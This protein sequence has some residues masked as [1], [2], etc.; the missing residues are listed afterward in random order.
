MVMLPVVSAAKAG[1]QSQRHGQGQQNPE[2]LSH[3]FHRAY[4]F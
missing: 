1:S 3:R 4:P 2:K